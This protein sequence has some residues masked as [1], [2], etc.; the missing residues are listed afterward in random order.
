MQGDNMNFEIAPRNKWLINVPYDQG[1]MY[2]LFLDVDGKKGW[3][4]PTDKESEILVNIVDPTEDE[5]T[6]DIPPHIEEFYE[7]WFDMDSFGFWT[8]E[9]KTRDDDDYDDYNEHQFTVIP[10]RD[11]K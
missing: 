1:L 6:I 10:V 2:C 8:F 11:I 5:H 3:R 7:Y 9:D 4:M